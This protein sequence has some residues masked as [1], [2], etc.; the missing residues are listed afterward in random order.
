MILG[1][2][3]CF[4]GGRFCQIAGCCGEKELIKFEAFRLTQHPAVILMDMDMLVLK[5]LDDLIDMVVYNNPNPANASRHLMPS[6]SKGGSRGEPAT[7]SSGGGD[8]WLLYVSDYHMAKPYAKIKP[9]QGGFAVLKPNLTIYRDIQRIVLK[10]DFDKWNGWKDASTG[11][12]TGFFWGATTFQG[13]LPFYFQILNSN[14][15]SLELD[16]CLHNNMNSPRGERLQTRNGTIDYCHAPTCQDCRDY[17][18]GDVYSVHF[19]N[20]MKP[21]TCQRHLGYNIKQS[22]CRE[23]HHA[24]FEHR[25]ALEVSWGRSGRGNHSYNLTDPSL[26]GYCS[27]YG[28]SGYEPIRQPYGADSAVMTVG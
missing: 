15:F 4:I 12:S 1:I 24:W 26:R 9:S 23:M 7:A 21:W 16:W 5:N 27:A 3:T 2:L 25:S 22:L 18:I 17:S 11:A 14:R 19:T 28:K 10:G 6:S 20:C 13:L 8:V